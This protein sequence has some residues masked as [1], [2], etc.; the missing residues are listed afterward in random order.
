MDNL[1]LPTIKN[2]HAPLKSPDTKA[3]VARAREAGSTQGGQ[4]IRQ[5]TTARTG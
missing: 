4:A 1:D 3:R 2:N 5:Y